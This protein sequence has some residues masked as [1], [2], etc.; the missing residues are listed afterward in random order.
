MKKLVVLAC[1]S[2]GY[3]AAET[4][5]LVL[6][7]GVDLV[8]VSCAGTVDIP[9][10]LGFLER[11]ASGVLVAACPLDNCLSL[12]G[13]RRAQQRIAMVHQAL[14]DAGEDESC[15]RLERISSVDGA[16]LAQAVEDML[17]ASAA[18]AR[19]AGAPKAATSNRKRAS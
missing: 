8:K 17:N 6:K 3:P 19:N 15:V 16:K 4:A 10:I 1:E 7:R 14:R 11:G 5:G 2:S 18:A 12:H 13:S 9:L